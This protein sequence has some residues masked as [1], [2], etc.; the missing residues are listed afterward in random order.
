MGFEHLFLL[1]AL[2][3][4]FIA[5]A[6][7]EA[8][9]LSYLRPGSVDWASVWAT[10]VIGVGRRVTDL[11]PLA[12]AMPGAQ[13][14]YEH[15]LMN[16]D[17]HTLWGGL[18][19]FLL[20]DFVFYGYHRA[21]HRCRWLWATHAVHH[22]STQLHFYA[23]FRLGWTNKIT[24]ALVFFVP[25]CV[26]GYSPMAVLTMLMM[27]LLLQMW[28]HS[29]WIPKLGVLEHVLNT[30]SH[31]RVHHATQTGYLD[32]NFGGLLIIFDRLFGTHALEDESMPCTYGLRG[33]APSHNPFWIV[34][35]EW[36]Q[37][38]RDVRRTPSLRGALTLLLGPPRI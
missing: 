9:V 4:V 3:A 8:F 7:A 16:L 27:N 19:L 10:S 30:P 38:L 14:L 2:P 11:V 5:V 25:L 28:L 37:L 33:T 31:H 22:S 13:W 29:E 18:V 35:R 21:S 32:K 17:S 15:R 20:I 1:G 24:L 12:V 23:A 36:W 6:M 34:L 26:L